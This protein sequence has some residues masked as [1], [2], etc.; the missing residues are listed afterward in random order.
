MLRAYSSR[1]SCSCS[2]AA[3]LVLP[4]FTKVSAAAYSGSHFGPNHPRSPVA[5]RSHANAIGIRVLSREAAAEPRDARDA[6]DAAA[7]AAAC[8]CIE[9]V[10]Q[11][12]EA[13]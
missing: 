9:S 5:L 7:E 3:S 6:G 12:D 10:V 11:H 13:N 8:A 2:L 1:S 4:A